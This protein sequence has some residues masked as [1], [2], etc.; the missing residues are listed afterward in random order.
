MFGCIS[1]CDCNRHLTNS[2]GHSTSAA[3]TAANE[4][5]HAFSYADIFFTSDRP[6]TNDTTY[7][8][9]HIAAN[10]YVTDEIIMHLEM[11]E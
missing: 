8:R 9:A 11:Q 4:P 1:L 2:V 7:K 5:E 6:V 3:K 10:I